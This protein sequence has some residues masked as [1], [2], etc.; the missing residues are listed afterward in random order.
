MRTIKEIIDDN[1]EYSCGEDCSC[2]IK[3][4]AEIISAI[5]KILNE[6]G[7]VNLD[8]IKSWQTFKKANLEVK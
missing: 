7:W 8:Y 5:E 6:T 4:V 1:L 3:A 2:N